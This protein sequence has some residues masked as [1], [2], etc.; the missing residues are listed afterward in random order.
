MFVRIYTDFWMHVL[1][2]SAKR[3]FRYIDL[4]LPEGEEGDML[5]AGGVVLSN[6]QWYL[7]EVRKI[8]E[9]RAEMVRDL[10]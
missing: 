1:A 8:G 7:S 5:Q 2:F 10:T 6:D 3:L 9:K 4:Y